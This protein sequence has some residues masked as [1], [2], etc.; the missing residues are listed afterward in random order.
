VGRFKNL[1][2]HESEKDDFSFLMEFPPTELTESETNRLQMSLVLG[3]VS[4]LRAELEEKTHRMKY[5]EET[6]TLR[7]LDNYIDDLKKI[8]RLLS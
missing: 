6:N 1:F 5:Y 8:E 2:N 3:A 4:E 7:E